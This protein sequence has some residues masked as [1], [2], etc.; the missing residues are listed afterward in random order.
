MVGRRPCCAKHSAMTCR[1]NASSSTRTIF[2]E[3][4]TRDPSFLG[5]AVSTDRDHHTLPTADLGTRQGALF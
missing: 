2:A 4:V 1:W 3:P 5:C